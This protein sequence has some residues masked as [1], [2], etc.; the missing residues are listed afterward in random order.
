[1]SDQE[2]PVIPLHGR[3]MTHIWKPGEAVEQVSRRGPYGPEET[4]PGTVVMV[5]SY[6]M[7]HERLIVRFDDGEQ[8]AINPDVMRHRRGGAR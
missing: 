7:R 8:R 6:L 3:S 5:E 1:M 2:G 4:R